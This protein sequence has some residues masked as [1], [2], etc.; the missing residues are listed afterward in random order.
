MP[1]QKNKCKILVIN[2]DIFNFK[3]EVCFVAKFSK[4]FSLYNMSRE[5]PEDKNSSVEVRE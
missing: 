3:L 2:M 5:E 4:R 1:Y